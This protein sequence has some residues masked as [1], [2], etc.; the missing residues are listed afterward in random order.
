MHA[1]S[2][3]DHFNLAHHKAGIVSRTGMM[4]VKAMFADALI[5]TEQEKFIFSSS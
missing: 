1:A 2:D 5:V 4:D 3:A